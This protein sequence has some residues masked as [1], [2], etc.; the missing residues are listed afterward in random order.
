VQHGFFEA[1]AIAFERKAGRVFIQ[2][3]GVSLQKIEQHIKF[4]LF[5]KFIIFKFKFLQ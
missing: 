4:M 5:N 1:R 2:S 3:S